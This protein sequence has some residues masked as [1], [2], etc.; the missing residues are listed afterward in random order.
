[1]NADGSNR[2]RRAALLMFPGP[3]LNAT[4]LDRIAAEG[5]SDV[6]VGVMHAQTLP[7][8]GFLFDAAAELAGLCAERSLG[9]VAFTGYMKY[10]E[11]LAMREPSRL[12]RLGGKG[13]AIDID[14]L[15]VKWLCPFREE[16][17]RDYLALLERICGWQAT[18][19]IHLNDEAALGFG[20][21][22]IGCYCDVCTK[23]FR[24]KAGDDPPLLE[25]WDS[26]LWHAWIEFRLQ[27]WVD[28]HVL[29]RDAVKRWRPDV[30]VGI[31][32]SPNVPERV[33]NA[34]KSG[35]SLGRQAM[36]LD[37]IATD[38]YQF[39]H[40]Q[41]IMHRPH[42]RI[43]SE[44]TRSLVGAC[45]NRQ[46]DLYPQGF[47]PPA[48]AAPMGRPD[49]LLAAIVPFALGAD[50]TMPYTYELMRAI[51]GFFEGFQDARRLDPLMTTHRPYAF[52][53]MVMPQQSEIYG[54]HDSNWG[55]VAMQR[56]VDVMHR[57]GLPWRWFW[58]E[59]LDDAG[60]QLTGPV[61]LLET[62]CLTGTQRAI[63][64]RACG[65]DGG[66][67]WIGNTP[68][69]DWG[70]SGKCPLP[71]VIERGRFQLELDESHPLTRGLDE[72]VLSTRVATP[73][74]E[75]DVIATWEGQPALVIREDESG[76]EVGRRAWLMG[77]PVVHD[78][79]P[80]RSGAYAPPLGNTALIARL[81]SWLGGDGPR[82]WMDPFPPDDDYRRLRP[83][84]RRN[85][86]CIELLPMVDD[87]SM[88]L[89]VVLYSPVG[90][91]T[92][93][94]FRTPGGARPT[95]VV[96]RWT[97]DDWADRLVAVDDGE[98]RIPIDITGEADP[99]AIQVTW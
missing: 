11:A 25:D 13:E 31:Q 55:A 76:G 90:S 92:N 47:M 20:D 82:A 27:G 22:S 80:G 50:M 29:L 2:L 63:L 61:V 9:L 39:N 93:L 49:G 16:N 73:A 66:Q 83:G 48:Q 87:E 23:A 95:Q 40:Y 67:L 30:A 45:M 89:I 8:Q 18:C 60:D 44:G 32:H 33:Y 78:Q 24:D 65:H 64:D 3:S 56:M 96:D 70:G 15:R 12:M 1:M 62:H 53:T 74:F 54:H 57:S 28:V 79:R 69:E 75:G 36:S 85:V 43:L 4:T 68:A 99:L 59:R 6:G 38:P 81:L 35:V 19:E 37:V 86:P 91:R 46:V 88:L 71:Q 84:D 7:G 77:Q 17:Q 97:G 21:G 5:F 52:A 34:W 10:Q 14:G 94:C 72:V 41:S 51:P 26:A 98:W 42:R 58:D